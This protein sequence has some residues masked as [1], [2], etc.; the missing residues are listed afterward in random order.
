M[1]CESFKTGKLRC[2]RQGNREKSEFISLYLFCSRPQSLHEGSNKF[3]ISLNFVTLNTCVFLSQDFIKCM[4]KISKSFSLIF[5]SA[6]CF[7]KILLI[8]LFHGHNFY[9]NFFQEFVLLVL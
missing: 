1:L 6:C 4:N 9:G 5:S 2:V 8:E 7:I 3:Q